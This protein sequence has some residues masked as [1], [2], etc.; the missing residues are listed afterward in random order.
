MPPPA[1]LLREGPLVQASGIMAD[2][3]IMLLVRNGFPMRLYYRVE[4]WAA[5]RLFDE[6]L[7]SVEWDV[8]V[9]FD[10]LNE[11]YRAFRV[12]SDVLRQL[13]VFGTVSEAASAV[14]R[15]LRAPLKASRR[16]GRQYYRAVLDVE[17]MSFNDLDEV[18]RWLRGELRP[19][20]RG[21]RNPGTALGR[22]VRRLFVRVLGGEQ[23]HLETRTPAFRVP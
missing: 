17:T 20:V 14:E 2:S 21:E 8:I 15:P 23:R 10:A 1:S 6:L 9:R 18:E 7:A 13:G 16:T 3:G 22:G 5:H 4:L 19:A 12:D 11:R